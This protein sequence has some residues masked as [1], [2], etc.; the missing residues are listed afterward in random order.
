MNTTTEQKYASGFNMPGYMPDS[1]PFVSDTFE[2]ARDCILED[3]E[4]HLD[5]DHENLTK[6]EIEE[7]EST[8]NDANTA[9]APFNAYMGNNV[10][11][12]TE[13]EEE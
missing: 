2:Y 12:V 11:W 4:R 13:A 6:E 3:M 9:T 7:W 8:I 10:Y 5:E 1:E